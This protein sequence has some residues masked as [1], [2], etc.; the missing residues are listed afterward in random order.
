MYKRILLK[1][2]GEALGV[3]S[4]DNIID[5]DSLNG[6]TAG[7]KKL[8]DQGVEVAVVIGAGNIWRG[9]VAEKI[10]IDRVPADFMGMLGTVI[11]A[12][13]MS[14]NLN[15]LGVPTEVYSAVPA[16]EGVTKPYD[17]EEAKKSLKE[18][19]ICFLAGGTGKPFFTTDTAAALRAIETECNAIL[20][21]K[22]GV[23]GVYTKDPNVYK[24]A[25]FL[26]EVT[27]KEMEEL[28]IQIMDASAIE[29]IKDTDL[30]ILVFSMSDPTNF[31]KAARGENVGT[32]CKKE[33]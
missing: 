3:K 30:E 7:I 12:V 14:S 23:K 17:Q 13:A 33:K 16:I 22:N 31:D 10:G 29:L 26:P 2:S 19:K 21:A 32:I 25:K 9:K 5:V 6:V 11:N 1:L 27:Y 28:K 20:M 24:D 4:S 8:H 15:R 18:G